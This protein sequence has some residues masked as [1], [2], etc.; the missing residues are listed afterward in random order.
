MG[1]FFA[2]TDKELTLYVQHAAWLNTAPDKAD[3]DKSTE[4]EPPRRD[5]YKPANDGDDEDI[6]MPPCQARH[7][8]YYLFEIGPTVAT[9]MGEDAIGHAEL[10]AWQANTGIALNAWEAR[11]LRRLS[12]AYVA[13]SYKAKKPDCPAPWKQASYLVNTPSSKTQKTRNAIRGLIAL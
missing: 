11:T 8:V 6:E 3:N 1:K 10:Q 9:G 13:Q 12:L 2:R 4:P 7:L 5:K